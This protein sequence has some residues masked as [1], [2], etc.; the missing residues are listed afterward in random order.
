MSPLET[1]IALCDETL[2]RLQTMKATKRPWN[3]VRGPFDTGSGSRELREK[4]VGEIVKDLLRT[5]VEKAIGLAP[6]AS[7]PPVLPDAV[8]ALKDVDTAIVYVN[9]LHT[10]A[11][12]LS[13]GKAD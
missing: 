12:S 10:W 5:L 9:R 13:S 3:D 4:G 11:T 1:F 8:R 7:E 2:K 6:K